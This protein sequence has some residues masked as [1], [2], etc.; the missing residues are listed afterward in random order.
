MCVRIII[1]IVIIIIYLPH[2]FTLDLFH[3]TLLVYLPVLSYHFP[4]NSQIV[5]KN[6]HIK[7]NENWQIAEN[8]NGYLHIFTNYNI[9]IFFSVQITWQNEYKWNLNLLQYQLITPLALTIFVQFFIF[10]LHIICDEILCGNV[11]IHIW[12]YLS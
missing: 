7:M 6:L 4:Q 9:L 11:V 3:A 5:K 12:Y 2:Q 1:V 8:P 10:I